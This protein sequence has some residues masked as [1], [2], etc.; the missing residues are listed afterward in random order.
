MFV[1]RSD[2]RLREEKP[3]FPSIANQGLFTHKPAPEPARSFSW[4]STRNLAVAWVDRRSP[5][6]L[7]E[8]V[9]SPQ[10]CVRLRKLSSS[11]HKITNK[12]IGFLGIE[13]T[14]GV[15]D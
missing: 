8:T 2:G 12:V 4:K 15:F 6:S 1:S 3:D 9:F 11:R 5:A 7:S 14:H 13:R 10:K